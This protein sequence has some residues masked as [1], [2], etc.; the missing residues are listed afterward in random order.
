[1]F[2][3]ITNKRASRRGK[4]AFQTAVALWNYSLCCGLF[5]GKAP[6]MMT[7]GE[8][9]TRR[10]KFSGTPGRLGSPQFRFKG[11]GGSS[12]KRGSTSAGSNKLTRALGIKGS[13]MYLSANTKTPDGRLH[14]WKRMET[15]KI[16]PSL[17]T[18][19]LPKKHED[20]GLLPLGVRES[21]NP[22]YPHNSR[23]WH[24]LFNDNMNK[25]NRSDFLLEKFIHHMNVCATLNELPK[26]NIVVN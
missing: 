1:M 15:S 26:V 3:L 18:R 23:P 13:G 11:N 7:P 25:G 6:G 16:R 12:K 22:L 19:T 14:L 20:G 24:C 2:Q 21:F 9:T 8:S 17:I 4:L 5:G 10:S